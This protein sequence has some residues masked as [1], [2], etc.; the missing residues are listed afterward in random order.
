MCYPWSWSVATH[1]LYCEQGVR[2][3]KLVRGR[4][5]SFETHHSWYI[6]KHQDSWA[7]LAKSSCHHLVSWRMLY[8]WLGKLQPG[9]LLLIPNDAANISFPSHH[10]DP[11]MLSCYHLLATSYPS[12]LNQLV[13]FSKLLLTI[14]LN[15]DKIRPLNYTGYFRQIWFQLIKLLLLQKAVG[16]FK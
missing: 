3:Q 7:A 12:P 13:S 10:P 15:R 9:Q 8:F 4:Y 11:F 14:R 2:N 16:L 5:S 1:G 6:R